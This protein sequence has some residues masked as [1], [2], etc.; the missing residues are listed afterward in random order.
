MGIST[1][2]LESDKRA[3]EFRKA[4]LESEMAEKERGLTKETKEMF[5][6]A[7]NKLTSGGDLSKA[8]LR[9]LFGNLEDQAF[10]DVYCLFDWDNDGSVDVHEFVLTMSLLATPATSFE[11]EQDLL[12]A[13]FDVD[14]SGTMDREEFGK[15][16]R[17]TLRCKMTHLDFC[18]K[19]EDRKATFRRHLEGEFS[20]ETLEFYSSV[21]QYRELV[22]SLDEEEYEQMKD[23]CNELAISI[24]ERFIKAGSNEEVNIQGRIRTEVTTTVLEAKEKGEL[25][26]FTIFDLAQQE[27]RLDE[28][29]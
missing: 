1:R 2:G 26:P 13:I 24:F 18:M 11:A 29:V 27:V 15:M 14:G 7:Y 19:T 21:D 25:I 5:K 9:S 16:M 23:E 20:T 12:F 10:E 28:D 17:A 6:S 3:V 22:Q 8:N 4:H